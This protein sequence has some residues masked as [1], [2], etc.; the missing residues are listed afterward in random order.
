MAIRIVEQ[1]IQ[2]VQNG[3]RDEARR[4]LRYAL[5]EELSPAL[6]A[7]TLMWLAETG[8]DIPFK[9][10]CYR[11]AAESD[12]QNNDVQQRLSYWLSQQLPSAQP[13][14]NIPA[15]PPQSMPQA[16]PP[17]Q[18]NTPITYPAQGYNAGPPSSM[19]PGTLPTAPYASQQAGMVPNQGPMQI[20]GQQRVVG[21]L[22]GPLG[23]GS[24][25]FVTREG[26]VAT[27]R[28]VTGSQPRLS[29]D[30]M[31][32]HRLAGEV[33]RSFP[34]YD[35]S[36]VKVNAY[37]EHLAAV[38]PSPYLQ[39]DAPIVVT[40]HGGKG[41]RSQRR[42]TR[43]ATNDT[44][45]FPTVIHRNELDAGGGPVYDAHNLLVGMMTRNTSRTNDYA[46]G[47]HIS[48]VYRCV[49]Q[50]AQE[51]QQMQGQKTIYCT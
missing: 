19:P 44:L 28:A 51:M 40:M 8:D 48:Q 11:Q 33:V 25:F 17:P 20:Q 22:G 42:N 35:I 3:N 29:I 9:V 45:W 32:G 18:Q 4:L 7:T 14:P 50:Y 46:Y 49:E 41:L 21:V 37:V 38:S 39:P 27:T 10:D 43:S 31:S 1:G 15:M 12:P 13:S 5:K 16:A 23:D 34:Q 36:L 47:L 2:A 24:G 6:R 26:L 30:L